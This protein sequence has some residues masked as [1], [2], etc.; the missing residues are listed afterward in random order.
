MRAF[1]ASVVVR[2]RSAFGLRAHELINEGL[3]RSPDEMADALISIA[4]DPDHPYN[5]DTLHVFLVDIPMPERDAFWTQLLYDAFGNAGHALD[6]L[7]RW[8]ARGPYASYPQDIIELACVPLIWSLASPNR[9]GRDYT[10]KVLAT[11][12]ID[13]P[14]LC[15]K[16]VERFAAVDDPYIK[17]RLA[18][19]ILG[20]ITRSQTDEI[21]HADAVELLDTLLT[22]FIESR[23]ALPDVLTRDYI[24]SL[25]R[26]L[27]RRKLIKP[28]LLQRA[29]PPYGSKPPKVPRSESYLTATYPR[30]D[31]R[32][33]GHGSLLY[34][35][36]SSH[37]DWSRYV[38]SGRV[39]DFLPVRLGDPLLVPEKPTEEPNYRVD[40]FAWKRFLAS[41]RPEQLAFFESEDESKAGKLLQSLAAEQRTLLDKVY[42]PRRRSRKAKPRPMA[43]PPERA[44]RFIFQRSIE[45][46][47][48]PERFAQFD[49]SIGRRDHGR[50]DHK[51]ERFGK[52]YQWIALYELL[53][54]LTDN[55]TLKDWHGV[56]VYDGAWQLRVR[57][58]D[59]TL[60]P[61][62]IKVGDDEEHV[63]SPTF[64]AEARPTW[65]SP[66]SPSFDELKPGGEAEWAARQADL[67]SPEEL[68]RITDPDSAHWL[69]VEGYHN[70]RD[71]PDKIAS[72]T[73]KAG[74][75][76]DLAILSLGTVV[77]L[78]DLP[79]LRAWLIEHPDLLRA[80]PDWHWDEIYGAFWSELP[81]ECAAH[82]RPPAW[83]RRGAREGG[84]LPVSSVAVSL[85]YGSDG[86][87]YDCSLSTS[88]SGELPSKFLFDLAGTRWSEP[89]NGWCDSTGGDF[90]QYRETDDGFH[91]DRALML[92]EPTLAKLLGDA[93]LA[94]AIGLFCERRVFDKSGLSIPTAL[95]WVDYAGH[96]IFDGKQWSSSK[97]APIKRWAT[98]ERGS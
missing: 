30:S 95:G 39:D 24:A 4:P 82:D 12:L 36:L 41:L 70:W 1:I 55:F 46:G 19:A 72:V 15:G 48:T 87:D 83:R 76:R 90:A 33:E 6:R 67:P 8:A 2:D 18:A 92:S 56:Q 11:L 35:A 88:A 98:A 23:G 38:V 84:K 44:A 10:T 89:R 85:G 58:I 21:Q 47:W 16:L 53:A 20:A 57:N 79:R 14:A 40:E 91:R 63:R 74:P 31:Q 86:S 34:S 66:K 69:I 78:A 37:S 73:A 5:A 50:A 28:S 3:N 68:L 45:L 43:F 81:D 26:W 59:P 64:P 52:K 42:L 96:L 49:S 13:R 61:E 17:Q 7:I 9:F 29:S 77:R 62:K 60:P 22:R 65:W 54:R 75:D 94:I 80:I 25:A 71:E 27:R 93:G 51:V 32:D 97:L